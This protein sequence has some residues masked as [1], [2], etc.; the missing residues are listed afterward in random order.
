LRYA[1]A[2]HECLGCRGLT[3]S[4][5][6]YDESLGQ[7]E[8]IILLETNTQPGMTPLSLAPEIAAYAGIAF[9]ELV[10]QLV[11][12]AL[13]DMSKHLDANTDEEVRHAKA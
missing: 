8:G 7:D 10:D 2:A 11:Q 5:F 12:L 13:R 4:D 3:R 6:I 9:D 1:E